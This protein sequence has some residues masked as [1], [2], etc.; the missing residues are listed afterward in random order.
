M[1]SADADSQSPGLS[2]DVATRRPVLSGGLSG[3]AIKPLALR[4][5]YD[6]AR[7]LRPLHPHIPLIGVGGI[8]STRDA[9]EFLLAGA[10]AIQIGTINLVNPRAGV[11]ILE[12]IEAFLRTEGIA[13]IKEIIG[14][15]L[16]AS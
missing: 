6:L 16:D 5:L 13:D 10:S 14:A 7:T 9:L 3:P 2:I 4:A 15:A 11:E 1:T 8:A 12:G